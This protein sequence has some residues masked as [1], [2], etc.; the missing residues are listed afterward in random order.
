MPIFLYFMRDPATAW[1]NEW[2]IGPRWGSEPANHGPKAQP[3]S[4][5]HKL[6]QAPG[7]C[8][9]NHL[10]VFLLS[11][12]T[13]G[14]RPCKDRSSPVKLGWGHFH[15]YFFHSP[16]HSRRWPYRRPLSV[17]RAVSGLHQSSTADGHSSSV[18]PAPQK[19]PKGIS[20]SFAPQHQPEGGK[21]PF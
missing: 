4:L 20:F 11:M 8:H 21:C 1:L 10:L 16:Q 6:G 14:P 5:T 18:G 17:S 3:A 12:T 7:I 2:C 19:I 13:E 9:F 15:S